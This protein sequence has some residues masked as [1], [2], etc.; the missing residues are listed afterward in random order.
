MRLS[1]EGY[2]TPTTPQNLAELKDASTCG[3][4]EFKP[5]TNI[6]MSFSTAMSGESNA[7]FIEAWQAFN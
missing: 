3:I 4:F 1:F 5:V 6:V 7:E 2:M